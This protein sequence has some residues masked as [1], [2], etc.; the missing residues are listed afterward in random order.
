M[1]QSRTRMLLIL[2]N[3][4]VSFGHIFVSH[5]FASVTTINTHIPHHT[6]M[7]SSFIAFLSFL[8]I[9]LHSSSGSIESNALQGH[10][11]DLTSRI[12]GGTIANPRRYPFY[13]LVKL[14]LSSGNSGFCGG[15]L[16]APDVVLTAA[17]CVSF[18]SFDSLSSVE[19]WVNSSSV[20]YSEYEYFRKALRWVAHP[21][22]D[23]VEYFND[24]ALIFLDVPVV[25]VPLVLINRNASFPS[26]TSRNRLTAIGLG[27]TGINT[28]ESPFGNNQEYNFP[29]YLMQV[30]VNSTPMLACWKAYGRAAIRQSAICASEE[31]VGGTCRGDSGGPLLIPSSTVSKNVQVG[32]TSW[33]S[34]RATNC[35]AANLPQVYT[36]VSYFAK[37]VDAKICQYSK[38]KPRSCPTL[39]PTTRKPSPKPTRRPTRKPSVKPAN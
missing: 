13:T 36:R 19:L 20:K 11:R 33:S 35:V 30:S 17:H 12:I 22:Y 23:A 18:D 39:K 4:G 27:A 26:D 7:S 21:D 6:M 28:T 24:I 14:Y 38:N 31:G 2:L 15:T 9:V 3:F 29:D 37:W 32:I 8:F 34:G 1:G 25:G 10:N 5:A 16:I